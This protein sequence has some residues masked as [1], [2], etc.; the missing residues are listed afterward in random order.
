MAEMPARKIAMAIRKKWQ[1]HCA[2][3]VL[4]GCLT[5]GAV[6][7]DRVSV[8]AVVPAEP[9]F[10]LAVEGPGRRVPP[11]HRAELGEA[12]GGVEVGVGQPEVV[13]HTLQLVV[14]AER[15]Q[16]PAEHGLPL[17]ARAQGTHTVQSR[18]AAQV[19]ALVPLVPS[20]RQPVQARRRRTRR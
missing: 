3:P 1:Y 20:L 8:V 7:L 15:E 12:L 13:G 17:L 10:E 14:G 2:H 19:K 5:V 11:F 18:L 4:V 6:P 16:C 9:V